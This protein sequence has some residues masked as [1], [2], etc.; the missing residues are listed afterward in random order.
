MILVKVGLSDQVFW[1]V[2]RDGGM[3]AHGLLDCRNLA[4]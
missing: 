2:T 1:Q 4:I 3:H